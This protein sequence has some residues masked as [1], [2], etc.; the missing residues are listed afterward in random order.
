MRY[1]GLDHG[2]KRIGLAVSDPLNLTAQSYPFIPN[3]TET[4]KA[5]EA[6]LEEYETKQIILGLPKDLNGKDGLKALEVRAFAEKLETDLGAKITFIDE[7]F[8]TKAVERHLIAA[9]VSRKKRKQVIDSQA[10]A[11]ILQ[12]FLDG[13]S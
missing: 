8:S 2:E 9:D 5:I 3:N 10:A 12:G 11:F 7:R 6:L 13:I 4:T 1:I